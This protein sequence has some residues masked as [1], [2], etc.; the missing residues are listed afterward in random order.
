M[1]AVAV[2]TQPLEPLAKDEAVVVEAPQ[3]LKLRTRGTP[4]VSASQDPNSDSDAEAK[5]ALESWYRPLLGPGHPKHTTTI[6]DVPEFLRDTYIVTG[7]RR[8]CYSYAA[9]MRSM[10]YVHNETGNVLTHLVALVIFAGLAAS[11]RLN[12]LPAAISPG[13]AAWGDYVVLYGYIFS[14]CVCFALSTLY[15]TFASHS[16]AHHVAWLKCDFVG[17]LIL[18]LGSF[19]PGL[20]YG[21]FES[22]ALM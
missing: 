11:T 18:I 3:I 21:Y 14:A 6:S 1:A 10:S 8:L 5:T 12:L 16:H 13:R 22:R 15:H 17:I 20:Y 7:Y 4:E 2:A 19:L 9:C